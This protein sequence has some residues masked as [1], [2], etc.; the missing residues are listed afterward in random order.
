MT[1]ASA[2]SAQT[3]ESQAQ[4]IMSALESEPFGPGPAENRELLAEGKVLQG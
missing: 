2:Q 3:E 1:R 4:K